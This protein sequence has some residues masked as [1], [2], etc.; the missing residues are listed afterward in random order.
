MRHIYAGAG[1][2]LPQ[3]CGAASRDHLPRLPWWRK[4]LLQAAGYLAPERTVR[5]ATQHRLYAVSTPSWQEQSTN[6]ITTRTTAAGSL[7]YAP[8]A[9]KLSWP[10]G[11]RRALLPWQTT[12]STPD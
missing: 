11:W 10:G 5:N 6:R 9:L 3:R 8:T 2:K 12:H 7:T 1:N 4:Q